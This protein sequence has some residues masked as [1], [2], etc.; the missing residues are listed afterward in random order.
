MKNIDLIAKALAELSKVRK[1]FHSEADFQHAFAW[2]LQKLSPDL[3]I[4]LEY[5][6]PQINA[7]IYIDV[8]ASGKGMAYAIELKYKTRGLRVE[9]DEIFNLLN[10]S[11]QDVGRYDFL[12]DIQ[13]LEQIVV[14]QPNTVGYAIMLTNDPSYWNLSKS[15]ETVDVNFRIHQGK[16]V[17]GVLGWGEGAS[18]GTMR[19]RE[20]P[21]IIKR[22]YLMDWRDYST[23]SES[24]YGKFKYLLIKV[25]A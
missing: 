11:A 7:R 18:K 19:S 10:Q 22:K 16:T 9:G 4:R 13:R 15:N 17:S 14:G 6:P 21:V 12:K 23:I 8:W 1:V 24:T 3:F 20:N 25:S 2:E 5:K